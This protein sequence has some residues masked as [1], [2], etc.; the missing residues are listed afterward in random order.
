MKYF[1]NLDK[2]IKIIKTDKAKKI[3]KKYINNLY[4]KFK[5]KYSSQELKEVNKEYNNLLTSLEKSVKN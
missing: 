2:R 1:N 5:I 4:D 3:L